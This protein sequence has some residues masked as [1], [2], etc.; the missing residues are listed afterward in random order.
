MLDAGPFAGAGVGTDV[1]GNGGPAAF[2]GGFEL[3]VLQTGTYTN[4][5]P[6]STVLSAPSGVTGGT[7]TVVQVGF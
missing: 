7:P 2:N 6:G 4:T 3:L 1:S 5:A